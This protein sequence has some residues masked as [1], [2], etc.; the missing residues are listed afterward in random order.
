[1]SDQGYPDFDE[2]ARPAW[3]GAQRGVQHRGW[4]AGH[5]LLR[6]HDHLRAEARLLLEAIDDH[7]AGRSSI[8]AARSILHELSA[9]QSYSAV[10]SLCSGFCTLLTL[11]HSIED[12]NVFPG[13]AGVEP[14]IEPVLQRLGEEHEII[15]EIIEL[16]REAI[17][18]AEAD[19][20]KA[21]ELREIAAYLCDRLSSHL[22]YE[23]SQ[24]VGALN[25]Y[26]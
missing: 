7:V 14:E 2:G 1:M 18:A 8:A 26:G 3:S 23:E 5:E 10:G 4:G 21:T 20:S 11:H 19:R 22:A 13:L 24:V 6:I 25:I 9:R 16:V 12:R 17:D 15:A